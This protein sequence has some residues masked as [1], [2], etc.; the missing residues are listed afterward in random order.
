MWVGDFWAFFR[1]PRIFLAIPAG[2]SPI[3]TPVL[4]AG[5]MVPD[6]SVSLALGSSL[7]FYA[8]GE[9]KPRTR[10]PREVTS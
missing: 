4:L 10:K 6:C 3:C 5:F 1:F 9:T 2:S 8:S 7:R